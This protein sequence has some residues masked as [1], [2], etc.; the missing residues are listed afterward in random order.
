[1]PGPSSTPGRAERPH[2]AG[3]ARLAGLAELEELAAMPGIITAN[4]SELLHNLFWAP[5]WPFRVADYLFP[6]PLGGGVSSAP[7]KR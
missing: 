7:E 6:T 3:L 5:M 1:M 4:V 2:T